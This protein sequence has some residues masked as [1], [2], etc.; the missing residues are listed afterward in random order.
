MNK[1]YEV[2]VTLLVTAE[3]DNDAYTQISD[4]GLASGAV[5]G[6]VQVLS[7]GTLEEA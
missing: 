1:E 3:D 5:I 2:E 6:T 7:L 4:S